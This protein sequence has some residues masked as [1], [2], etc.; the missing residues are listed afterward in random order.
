MAIGRLLHRAR[1]LWSAAP[2]GPARPATTAGAVVA[3]VCAVAGC[4]PAL[5]GT[6][7][8]PGGPVLYV[9]NAGDG[10]LT[11]IDATAG[12][13]IG[14]AVPGGAAPW[15]LAVGPGGEVLAQS[16]TTGAEARL[17]FLASATEGR[18]ARPLALEPGA[19]RPLL[20]G[21]GRA[22]AGAW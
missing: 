9:A 13:V 2:R 16:T 14:R 6:P 18:R 19:R 1:R 12:R 20:A 4:G 8:A 15:L 17:T 10:T 22:A 3:L 21:G 5:T 11:R 7:G